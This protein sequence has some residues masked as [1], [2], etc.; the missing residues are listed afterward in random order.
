MTLLIP[1]YDDCQMI[2]KVRKSSNVI[3][4]V[5]NHHEIHKIAD[6]NMKYTNH[7]FWLP[8]FFYK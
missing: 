8:I 2:S 7:I 1:K 3:K 6:A 4:I 5:R